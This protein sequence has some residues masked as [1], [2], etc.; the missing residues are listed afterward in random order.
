MRYG[1]LHSWQSFTKMTKHGRHHETNSA[2]YIYLWAMLR[3]KCK[4]GRACIVTSQY[5][6][7]HLAT[8]FSYPSPTTMSKRKYVTLLG[9]KKSKEE[10][11][12]FFLRAAALGCQPIF[13]M[14]I[15]ILFVVKYWTEKLQVF[16][17]AWLFFSNNHKMICQ[18]FWHI[19]EKDLPFQLLPG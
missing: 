9:K 18:G 3:C 14:C 11:E 5:M 17:L 15:S 12:A 13:G 2:S 10:W 8:C 6:F 4:R 7:C 1:G 19:K 16:C